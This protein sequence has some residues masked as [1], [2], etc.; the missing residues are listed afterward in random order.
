MPTS[1]RSGRTRLGLADRQPCP[2][3]VVADS[4]RGSGV[5]TYRHRLRDLQH[6]PRDVLIYAA[7]T[8][9]R[10]SVSGSNQKFQR[11]IRAMRRIAGMYRIAKSRS[12]IPS[13]TPGKGLLRNVRLGPFGCIETGPR[14]S[15][16]LLDI[17]R[18]HR[19]PCAVRCTSRETRS[20]AA[21]SGTTS[22]AARWATCGRV[23]LTGTQPS[24]RCISIGHGMSHVLRE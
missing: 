22:S 9:D 6:P 21:E 5:A 24:P 11:Q 10:A 18:D 15:P 19:R 17:G 3:R 4:R 20:L 12:F 2:G 7:H 23:R 16:I 13:V 1:S 14:M 8:V